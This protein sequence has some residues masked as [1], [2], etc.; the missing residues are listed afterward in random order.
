MRAEWID[1]AKYQDG[2]CWAVCHDNG[3]IIAEMFN[4]GA[5]E[6]SEKYARKLSACDDLAHALKNI[7]EIT[8]SFPWP[9]GIDKKSFIKAGRE[10][11]SKRRG[12]ND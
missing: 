8:S 12:P 5:D 4:V 6:D 7:I 2:G 9:E 1:N 3:A 10:A 11:L